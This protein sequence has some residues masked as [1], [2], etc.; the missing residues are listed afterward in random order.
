MDLFLQYKKKYFSFPTLHCQLC[1]YAVFSTH[2]HTLQCYD[3]K[4]TIYKTHRV[5]FNANNFNIFCE[6]APSL[7]TYNFS[8]KAR[9]L[10]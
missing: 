1:T 3:P 5:H 6:K 10:L 4:T 7:I 9:Y 2:W 8:P